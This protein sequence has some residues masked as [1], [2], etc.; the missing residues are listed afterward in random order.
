MAF[1]LTTPVPEAIKLPET[2]ETVRADNRPALG[3]EVSSSDL[4]QTD[5]IGSAPEQSSLSADQLA[6]SS[7]TSVTYASDV[8]AVSDVPPGEKDALLKQVEAILADDSIMSIY[9]G[10]PPAT[11]KIFKEEGEK[12]ALE[13]MKMISGN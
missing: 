3:V 5:A 8:T 13:I 6:P 2:L 1:D 4:E 11:Q 7:E 10:L 12:L 9:H